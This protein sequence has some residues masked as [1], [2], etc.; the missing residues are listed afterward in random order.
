MTTEYKT[1]KASQQVTII[2]E[3]RQAFVLSFMIGAKEGRRECYGK[4]LYLR[5]LHSIRSVMNT[6]I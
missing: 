2:A 6:K 5:S 3:L 4:A 1:Q